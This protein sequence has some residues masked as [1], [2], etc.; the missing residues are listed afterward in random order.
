MRI[1]LT[2]A[3]ERAAKQCNSQQIDCFGLEL[4]IGDP[5]LTLFL[6]EYLK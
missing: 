5:I 1:Y 2:E 3:W 6:E 4:L